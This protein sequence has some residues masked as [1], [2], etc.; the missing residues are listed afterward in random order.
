M[1]IFWP[2][3]K[4]FLEQAILHREFW[5]AFILSGVMPILV[6][7]L[8]WMAL[9]DY[10]GFADL[11]GWSQDQFTVYYF[12]NFIIYTISMTNFHS[13]FGILVQT[14]QL[15]Y[16]LLRPL[17]FSH[18][19]LSMTLSR[20][21]VLVCISVLGLGLVVLAIPESSLLSLHVLS[22]ALITI[23]L[24]VALLAM[25][26]VAIGM[27]AFWLIQTDGTFAAILLILQFF[28]GL[29]LPL[30]FLPGHL[31]AL[32]NALPLR[33]AFAL[34]AEA[35][36]FPGSHSLLQIVLGQAFWLCIIFGIAAFL[37][38]RGTKHY[39]AIGA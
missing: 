27:L 33:Y 9:F 23:P 2:L 28:G 1:R 39:D 38:H 17:K 36:A 11:G 25:I 30:E 21:F 16:W 8:A 5:L 18:F 32:S 13:E 14:G 6:P 12:A 34:P 31:K 24:A 19:T 3:T 15:N 26:N 7:L 10:T 37:W 29:I 35:I 20:I 22:T 4:V